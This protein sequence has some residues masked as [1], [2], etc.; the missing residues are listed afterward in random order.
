[1]DLGEAAAKFDISVF[2]SESPDGVSGRFE[3]NTDLFDA[4]T[5]QRMI[6]HYRVLLEAAIATPEMNAHRFRSWPKPSVAGLWSTGTRPRLT[7]HRI[8]ACTS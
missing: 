5:I 8:F 2:L 1:M 7:I 4:E 6:A 3:F